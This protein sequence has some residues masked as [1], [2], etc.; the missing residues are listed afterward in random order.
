MGAVEGGV[1][2]TFE[3]PLL[4]LSWLPRLWLPGSVLWPPETV[5]LG[6]SSDKCASKLRWLL[7]HRSFLPL[8]GCCQVGSESQL[9]L[10]VISCCYGC[11][12]RDWE[13]RFWLPEL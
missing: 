7:S 2:A 5:F 6:L 12:E 8:R 1:S 9:F 3:T 13:L 4:L 11:C 10:C